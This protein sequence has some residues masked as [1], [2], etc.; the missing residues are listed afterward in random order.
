VQN[1]EYYTD[2][3]TG[4]WGWMFV[5]SKMPELGDTMFLVKKI[6]LLLISLK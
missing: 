3:L 5:M 1:L 4:Y 6:F 2:P